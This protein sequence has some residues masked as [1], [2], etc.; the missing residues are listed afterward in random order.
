MKLIRELVQLQEADNEFILTGKGGPYAVKEKGI[1]PSTKNKRSKD[2]KDYY[3][4]KNMSKAEAE[5]HCKNLGGERHGVYVVKES[6]EEDLQE[7]T[8]NDQ[9]LKPYKDIFGGS[10]P[11]VTNSSNKIEAS[12]EK[13][14]KAPK[15]HNGLTQRIKA[16]GFKLND[17]ETRKLGGSNRELY[18]Y[19]YDN[20]KGARVITSEHTGMGLKYVTFKLKLIVPVNIS[21]ALPGAYFAPSSTRK[22][23]AK[24]YAV[25]PN[26]EHVRAREIK[27]GNLIQIGKKRYEVKGINKEGGQVSF[28]VQEI[29]KPNSVGTDHF[30]NKMYPDSLVLKL[31][32]KKVKEDLNEGMSPS[33]LR[34]T[35]VDAAKLEGFKLDSQES[36]PGTL[37]AWM[38]PTQGALSDK[39]FETFIGK[40][41]KR[42]PELKIRFQK[43]IHSTANP[44]AMGKGFEIECAHGIIIVV[45]RKGQAGQEY[46]MGMD[47]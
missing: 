32:P 44:S 2:G 46:K 16:A 20:D 23:K 36:T 8:I 34:K 22:K 38:D 37:K 41:S 42:L 1:N 29:A 6:L 25:W 7:A 39:D 14:G 24:K 15:W 31:S 19:V 4:A 3:V 17:E 9:Y 10:K 11:K 28:N 47:T 5:K 13:V 21:E 35:I 12:L 45:Y 27:R 30:T 26:A 40:L 33:A 18:L 43:P